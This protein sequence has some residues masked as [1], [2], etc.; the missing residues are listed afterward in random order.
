[1]SFFKSLM[2]FIVEK[3]EDVCSFSWLLDGFGKLALDPKCVNEFGSFLVSYILKLS[4]NE[5]WKKKWYKTLHLPLRRAQRQKN[6]KRKASLL[7][8]IIEQCALQLKICMSGF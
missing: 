7:P 2:F 6:G 1:M 4:F 5:R 3:N 8:S